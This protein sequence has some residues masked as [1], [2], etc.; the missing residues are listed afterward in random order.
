MLNIKNALRLYVL[1]KDFVPDY[2]IDEDYIEFVSEIVYNIGKSD[3]PESFG[4]S[5]LLM[6]PKISVEELQEE[7]SLDVVAMFMSGLAENKFMNLKKFCGALGY[8]G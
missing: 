7:K 2:E 3:R 5:I 6:F 8:G 1:L 4:E